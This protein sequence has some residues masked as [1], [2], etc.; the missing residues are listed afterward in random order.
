MKNTFNVRKMIRGVRITDDLIRELSD[1]GRTHLLKFNDH[2][3]KQ[4]LAHFEVVNGEIVV[5]P[6]AKHLKHRCPHCGGR[7]LITS[8]GYYCEHCFGK[9]PSCKFHCN[10]ILSH[11][12]ILPHELEA[13]LDGHPLIIDG[14]FNSQGKI[15]SAKLIENDLMGMSLTSIVGKC[16]ICGDDVLVSPVAFNCCSHDGTSEP[17]HMSLWR[18]VKGHAVT[19]DELD[20]LLTDG[21]TSKEVILNDEHGSLSKAFL[22]LSDDKKRIVPHY[23]SDCVNL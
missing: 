21:I 15:F 23:V 17:Y 10:G 14:C 4:Y 9:H 12:F 11:R 7:I 1:T 8:K 16:P 3:G 19:L 22:R 2:K 18:H 5:V 20:E 13:H 6:E